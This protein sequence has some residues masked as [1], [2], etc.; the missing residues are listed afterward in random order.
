MKPGDLVEA[1]HRV[2][3]WRVVKRDGTGFL[4]RDRGPDE[5]LLVWFWGAASSYDPR[6]P[7]QFL[8]VFLGSEVDM[9]A[10]WTYYH[11]VHPDYGELVCR[12]KTGSAVL[13]KVKPT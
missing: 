13:V 3:I 4:K 8:C 7:D 9:S 6:V 5:K 10:G 11:V 1:A 12:Y 2:A